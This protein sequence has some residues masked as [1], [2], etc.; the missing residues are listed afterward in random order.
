MRT[1]LC[2]L[3][4]IEAPIIQA[5]IGGVTCPEL[6][7][8]VS[9]AG[10]LG[11][12]ALTGHGPD[13]V[14]RAVERLRALTDR[15]FAANLLL[16]HDVGRELEASLE[17][18]VPLVS[19]FWGDASPYVARVHGAGARLIITVGS[20][21]E[22]KRA[23]DAGCDVIVA[24]GWEAGGH[25]RGTVA[26][27]ALVPQVVDAV[28]PLP[29]V[30]A[31]GIADGRGLAAVLALGAQA[32]WIGTRFLA[33]AE[34]ATHPHYLSRI[35]A[36]RA[37]D[38][39]YGTLFDVGWPDAPHRVLENSTMRKWE[40]AGRPRPGSRPGEGAVVATRASGQHILRYE[41]A[42][43][44][45][46]HEGDIEAMSLWAGQGVGLVQRVQP[47]AGIVAEFKA[48]ADAVVAALAGSARI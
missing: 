20:V 27:L 47:A 33:A 34:A 12:L 26:T 1:P 15:P 19:L 8:A 2:A 21:D 18:G 31:G 23:A 35:L 45:Y 24:Q 4:G 13:G 30:A 25:V 9:N 16:P 43:A 44:R 37:E 38:A 41:S 7:A 6:A 48:E 14:R 39:V 17:I 5:P 40:A 28:S 22:A 32:G 3:L 29:V 46:D 10:G 42:S 11:T 36:A